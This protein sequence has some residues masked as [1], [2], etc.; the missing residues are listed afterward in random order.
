MEC[1]KM[2]KSPLIVTKTGN[3]NLDKITRAFIPEFL[4]SFFNQNIY[5]VYPFN[6]NFWSLI[7]IAFGYFFKSYG[8]I[9][10]HIAHALWEYWEIKMAGMNISD[11]DYEEWIDILMDTIFSSLP[12][13]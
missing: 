10:M 5:S 4:I 3:T 11:I 13:I 1:F 8:F 6:I 7:H 9:W 12:F 2:E